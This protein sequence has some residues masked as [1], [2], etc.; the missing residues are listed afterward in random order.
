MLRII[1]T[2]QLVGL[3]EEYIEPDAAM[4]IEEIHASLSAD[5]GTYLF[6]DFRNAVNEALATKTELPLRAQKQ[7]KVCFEYLFP[8]PLPA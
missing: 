4:R 8:A 3:I 2:E 5:E 1:V 7:I 6:Q